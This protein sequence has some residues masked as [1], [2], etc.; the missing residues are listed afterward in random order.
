[1]WFVDR[2]HKNGISVILDWVPAHFCKDAHGLYEFDG[3]CCYEYSDPNKWE[4][5]SWGTRVFDY[6]RPEV[7]SFLFSSARFWLE[8]YHM[9]GLRV[10][11][12]SSMLYLDY[13]R[14]DGEWLPNVNGGHENLEAIKFFQDLNTA[15]F[16]AHPDVLMVAEE[17]TAWPKVT[18]P[19]DDGAW[20]STS[21]GTWAG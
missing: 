7:K 18:K 20:A 10:D 4:H 9:D 6:G 5:A 17:S 11:A 19:V 2:M 21:S 15:I 16:A 3:G 14:K 8:E 12:V 13:N 1:M